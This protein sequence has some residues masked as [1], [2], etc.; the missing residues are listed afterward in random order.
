M[1]SYNK[2]L[3][4]LA[5]NVNNRATNESG[6]GGTSNNYYTTGATLG[7]DNVLT[8]STQATTWT[9]NLNALAGTTTPGGSDTQVQFNDSG[10]FGANSSF[11]YNGTNVTI[12]NNLLLG[13][14][15]V[16]NGDTD[17]YLGFETDAIK[18]FA[19]NAEQ[20]AI[21][22]NVLTLGDGVVLA[23]HSSDDFTIDSPN[24]IILDFA[25]DNLVLQSAGATFGKLNNNGSY[26]DFDGNAGS[27]YLRFIPWNGG[28]GTT[29]YTYWGDTTHDQVITI[30]GAGGG[31]N[32]E[33]TL[34]NSYF[35]QK[36][37]AGNIDTYIQA[38]GS[39]YF[40]NPVGF[41]TN[42]PA[43]ALNVS[44][45]STTLDNGSGVAL[46]L[47]SGGTTYLSFDSYGG[48]GVSIAAAA[49]M[50]VSGASGITLKAAANGVVLAP[51][52][53]SAG[54]TLQLKF[55]EL[56]AGGTA[57]VSLQAPDA[58][59]SDVKM[60]LPA[61]AG[62]ANQ[63]LA[64][65]SVSSGVMTLGFQTNGTGTIG[66]S[67]TDNQIAFG[68]STA[69]S[70]E[71]SANFTFD[72]TDVFLDTSGGG[73]LKL[74]AATE[75][76][77]GSGSDIRIYASDNVLIS[78]TDDVNIRA[79]DV[80]IETT[81]ASEYARFDGGTQRL[82]IGTTAPAQSLDVRGTTLLS[83]A[84]DTVP[85][86]VFAYGAGT[87]AMHVTSGSDTGLGTATPLAKLHINAGAYQQ[88]F[89]RGSYNHTIVKG[90]SDDTLTFATGAPGSHTARFKIQ[91]TGVDVVNALTVTGT[92][93]IGDGS[94]LATSAA[95]TA[96]AQIANKKY[97]DDSISTETPG[98][99]TTQMQY[100]NG[101]AFGGTD[102]LYWI[103]GSDRLY[104]SGTTA[105]LRVGNYGQSA[106]INFGNNADRIFTDS[107]TMYI[108]NNNSMI[109]NI[110]SNNNHVG[111]KYEWRHNAE[112]AG[113]AA[114]MT[115]GDDG[116]LGIGTT[117]PN[118][119]LEVAGKIR[120][121]DGTTSNDL[122][123]DTAETVFEQ[124]G[125]KIFKIRTYDG[126]SYYVP[127]LWTGTSATQNLQLHGGVMTL[128][129]SNVGI[130]TTSPQQPLHVLTSAND[131]GILIDVSDD[132]HEGRLL[133]GDTSSN[134][135]GH[136]GYN[137]SLDAM[138]F[139][140]NGAES[141]RLESDQ[142]AV[143]Y[144]NITLGEAKAI[145]FDSTDT[146]ITTNTENPEDLFISAD[147]DLFLRPDNDILV[148]AGTSTYAIFDGA[149]QKVGIGLTN[150]A[151]FSDMLSVQ[152]G[153]NSGW[154]I[155]FTNAAE[156]VKGAIRTD[157]GDNYI[158]FASKSESDIRLFYNDNEANTALIVKGS[159]ATA[160]NVGIGTTSPNKKLDVMGHFSVSSSTATDAIYYSNGNAMMYN[161]NTH[162]FFYGGDTS[163]R[164]IANDG[165]TTFM[166][167]MNSGK[168]GIGTD[169]PPNLLT[170]SGNASPIKLYGTS[171][172]LV[173]FDVSTSGDFTIDADDD[174]RL[175]AGG[176]DI[177]L[178]GAGAEFGRLTNSSQDF[179]IQNTQN[180]KDIIFKTVE[181]TTATEVMRIDG[182]ESNL[183]IPSGNKIQ[184]ADT[185]RYL[186]Q[187]GDHLWINN[188]ETDGRINMQAKTQF[189]F[190]VDGQQQANLSG[191]SSAGTGMFGINVQNNSIYGI[192]MASGTSKLSFDNTTANAI[193]R[194]SGVSFWDSTESY[195]LQGNTTSGY[196]QL[197]MNKIMLVRSASS[198]ASNILQL[199][200]GSTYD[201]F[202]IVEDQRGSSATNGYVK[203]RAKKT[204]NDG[205]AKISLGAISGSTTSELLVD[206]ISTNEAL[207]FDT[208]SKSHAFDIAKAG[209]VS[210]GG[211]VDNTNQ[212]TVIG[213]SLLSG[214]TAITGTLST[215]GVATLGDNSVTN[216][217]TAG[218][219]STRIATTAFV[220]AA[221]AAGGGG[222]G[223]IGGSLSD[224]YIPIGTAA[225]TIGNFVLGLAENN[226]IWIGC[227][228]TSTTDSA[229]FNTSLGVLNLDSITT[230]DANTTIGYGAGHDL[231]TGGSN[232]FMG[233]STG[234]NVTTGGSNDAFGAEALKSNITGSANTAIGKGALRT[235]NYSW[236]TAV[237]HNAARVYTGHSIVAMGYE[238]GSQNVSG[239]GNTLIGNV[240]F[241]NHAAGASNTVIGS[242]SMQGDGTNK[243]S[244]SSNNTSIGVA[245]MKFASGSQSSVAIGNGALAGASN[246]TSNYTVA[247]GYKAASGTTG[248]DN[249][250]AVGHETLLGVSSGY[251][252]TAIGYQTSYTMSTGAGNTHLGVQAGFSGSTHN[253]TTFIGN[254]AGLKNT[255]N[256]N[257]A[258]GAEAYLSGSSATQIVA[259]GRSAGK[260]ITTGQGVIAIGPNAAQENE[261]G[262]HNVA[263]GW[264]AMYGA[265][266][267]ADRNVGIG[268]STLLDI[269][270]G[271]SNVGVGYQAGQNISTGDYNVAIGNNA[272]AA[273]TT[274]ASNVAVGHNAGHDTNQADNVMVGSLSGYSSESSGS[275][276]LGFQAGYYPHG[277]LNTFIGYKSGKGDN[278]GV[279]TAQQ[280]VGVGA[281][282]LTAVTSAEQSVAIGYDAGKAITTA[283]KTVA[284]GYQA[285]ES[286]TT[287]GDNVLIG[288]QTG[289][290]TTGQYNVMLGKGAGSA[291]TTANSNVFIGNNA[292][293]FNQDGT[294][295]TVVGFQAM[296]SNVS[297]THNTI[298]GYNAA[299]NMTAGYNTIIG[300]E[301]GFDMTTGDYNVLMGV[302]AGAN[303]TGSQ[304]NVII[305]AYAGRMLQTSK[306]LIAIGYEAGYMAP[307]G[308]QVAIGHAALRNPTTA[309]ENL[310]VGNEALN[311]AG[312]S[313]S[314]Y[315]TA[316]GNYALS[317]ITSAERNVAVGYKALQVTT[318]GDDNVA[319]G[320]YAGD[321]LTEAG[322]N[323][324]IGKEA[325]TELTTGP[326]NVFIGS[327][328]GEAAVGASYNIA[329]GSDAYKTATTGN[330]NIAIGK[331]AMN[332]GLV[333]SN[334]NIG[335]GFES[336]KNQTGG[337]ENVSLGAYSM[338]DST[339][340]QRNVAIGAYAATG[341]TAGQDNVAVGHSALQENQDGDDMVAI[342]KYA[343]YNTNPT[344]GLGD[345]VV[346]GSSAG[347]TNTTG[348]QNVVIGR[349]AAYS[350][351][352]ANNLVVIGREAGEKITTGSSNVAI[353]ARAGYSVTKG[354]ENVMIGHNAGYNYAGTTSGVYGAFS[355]FIGH[356]AGYGV[357]G[358]HSYGNVM[359][360]GHQPMYEATGAKHSIAIGNSAVVS[361]TNA[362]DVVA[363]GR[364][365]GSYADAT[366]STYIGNKA[367]FRLSG[368]YN[369]A[370]GYQALSGAS[371]GTGFGTAHNNVAIGYQSMLNVTSGGENVTIGDQAG[372]SITSADYSVAIGSD[373]LR[374][375]TTGFGNIGIGRYA[376]SALGVDQYTVAI[377]SS[378]AQDATTSESVLI[379]QNAGY[380]LTGDGN[381]G[382]GKGALFNV[383]SGGGNVAIGKNAGPSSTN[384]DSNKLYINNA[385]G[386]PLIGGDFS[387]PSVTINGALGVTGSLLVTGST[388]A[389]QKEI[390]ND[391][392]ADTT[393]SDSYSH[394]MATNDNQGGA[395][396]TLTCP[397]SP[398]IGDEYWIVAQGI[399][400]SAAPG[401]ALV[402]ITPNTGQ[403]INSTVVPGSNIALISVSSGT[404]AGGAP[405]VKFKTAHLIC[406]DTNTW[407]LTLSAEGPTS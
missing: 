33:T 222:G 334:F 23:P 321:A 187:N 165:S 44:G 138:R 339:N 291:N 358:G 6:G 194:G 128:S 346:I 365:A 226:S 322:D 342:G 284:I 80:T 156:D 296:Y 405:L 122:E 113:G 53:T 73:K 89:T 106:G 185:N 101:G 178:M 302:S 277:N 279:H 93:T 229:E 341:M 184:F 332:T 289:K 319:V 259:I 390:K 160:G 381:V 197:D 249:N 24:D 179:I 102:N 9:A 39:S 329:I 404:G 18:F 273:L 77:Q 385:A 392:T 256:D 349:K 323:V 328:A 380:S 305:G 330:Y 116:N 16:H 28:A 337:A 241:Y 163:T 21:T 361:G 162:H 20:L 231:N 147:Q 4:S 360:I 248:G 300:N 97:V 228:P 292:A 188:T 161:N 318:T 207:R 108:Q 274:Y 344:S 52:G 312:S 402:S 114:L 373:A 167:L 176:Q 190:Y 308:Y 204:G 290:N 407:V 55:R 134:A 298:M 234:E 38:G 155:G 206:S 357:T 56:A 260:G 267:K 400:A 27:S 172:G 391:I 396:T 7:G 40:I 372:Y 151:S 389:V 90:N 288:H 199:G 250:V 1:S 68:A 81:S 117:A 257:V 99:S 35:R 275:T 278:S 368:N 398:S 233:S 58:I 216:T 376:G 139:F 406:V 237:G 150:P 366:G 317:Q 8:G 177:A 60:V 135:I 132:T 320:I 327:E 137:H 154:P 316:I 133:F 282:A 87:S 353:G 85:F 374:A 49:D 11:T 111:Q 395:T 59:A 110:D 129:G 45:N 210:V 22:D 352:T 403:T 65:D 47:K 281:N 304:Q 3:K 239:G 351:T 157:Q 262:T 263:I 29:A 82:G 126:S 266:G 109:F 195:R 401:S 232:T 144:G 343:A 355:T 394:Y 310:A 254:S 225:D 78:P 348:V 375:V 213:T 336:L 104:L 15:L 105:E 331:N 286:I 261:D 205:Y 280:N 283:N 86:E 350:G 192:A 311:G 367:G 379:G 136:I 159:G 397:S 276:F 57:T 230:G 307:T 46:Y 325:G 94:T 50:H 324:L 48:P 238:A 54:D 174:I 386:T 215:T 74:G 103:D 169:S 125:S 245:A 285:G 168:L 258:I 338:L 364:G 253:N 196:I 140:T 383:T 182:S 362:E 17:T 146:S 14:N 119:K 51:A 141:L 306:R 175:D 219:N 5:M 13:S 148:Q 92:A 359:A 221:V 208:N 79:D 211:A 347:F 345:S 115:L 64:I 293:A 246:N 271:E 127:F 236:N 164:W 214:N 107:Y 264:Q 378:A 95:P 145:Y 220:T 42:S 272:L 212:F 31:G 180:D 120:I 335:I 371:S 83:G 218:N 191:T 299:Q 10:A 166:S 333:T 252:N 186:Y 158:A 377:G 112:G 153:T 67:I 265:S 268:T 63:V 25:G 2:L 30:Q 143:F 62:T 287:G 369:V 189:T 88:V 123:F 66:G 131:K 173:E 270:T 32:N 170:V 61:S 84:T 193:Y 242:G 181:S 19:N 354:A 217:Q 152:I 393:L 36:D 295:N 171:S 142:D 34:A 224:N 388:L 202:S 326:E 75:Y 201:Q 303:I 235:N 149:E 37:G 356:A 100:N 26:W 223:T 118:T 384:T 69:N 387:S 203:L 382:I 247:I 70:I 71:G 314:N 340:A 243:P 363:L 121:D 255:S 315:N 399:Y 297:S 96:D 198:A 41:G 370:L 98:G 12:A 43:G 91:P 313:T 269:S 200:D 227:D 294:Q 244:S 76:I 130:G 301:A 240:A 124:S 183:V 209:Y 251:S 309:I 72:G